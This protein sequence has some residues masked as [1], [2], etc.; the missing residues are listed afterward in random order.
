MI[1]NI[2]KCLPKCT[3]EE[4]LR[5]CSVRRRD[6]CD[7]GEI[8]LRAGGR[9]SFV[10]DGERIF[11]FSECDLSAIR[12][13]LIRVCE[14][15]IY[16]HRD[17]IK[18]GYII[19]RGGVR[20]GVCGRAGYECGSLVGIDDVTSLLFRIPRLVDVGGEELLRAFKE[21]E[22]GLLIFSPPGYGKTTALRMLA[23]ALSSGRGALETVIVDERGELSVCAHPSRSLD[24]LTG[25]KKRS[26]MEIALRTLSPELIITD[27]IGSR[28]ECESIRAFLCGGVKVIASAHARTRDDLCGRDGVGELIRLGVFDV[29]VGI[30]IEDG[31]RIY[32][33]TE[34]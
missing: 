34:L 4:L 19:A 15:S 33:K 18:D 13:T 17:T 21:C 31:R 29:A 25:Y 22:R 10:L 8:R 30:S 9:S 1:K 16:P 26:G 23:C 20:V 7:I 2:L 5:L 24:I 12:D 32:T 6:V 14:G 27:E 3:R 11:L 28:D